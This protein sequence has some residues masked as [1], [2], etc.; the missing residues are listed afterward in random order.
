V[1]HDPRRLINR[2]LV[3]AILSASLHRSSVAQI[4][5]DSSAA[6]RGNDSTIVAARDISGTWEGTFKLD[7]AWQLPERASARSVAARLRF[8]PVGDAT[9]TT[10]SARS[11]HAGT[12]EIDFSRFGFT[13]STRESLG[14]SVGADSMH[15]M[16][17]PTV[18]HGQVEIHGAFRGDAVSGTWRY[19]TDPGGARGTFEIRKTSPR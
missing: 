1:N 9:P 7:S 17:N 19:A 11:V 10:S 6:T 2:L 18:G 3:T 5:P 14:W 16:L 4:P 15:A 8:G 13:L 12:F